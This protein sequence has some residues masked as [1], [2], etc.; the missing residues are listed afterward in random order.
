[1]HH[2]RLAVA[3]ACAN[4]SVRT[5]INHYGGRLTRVDSSVNLTEYGA[6]LIGGLHV[7]ACGLHFTEHEFG[8]GVAA[9]D[10]SGAIGDNQNGALISRD[11]G[12][13]I[14]ASFAMR[15]RQLR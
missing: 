10:A 15:H 2:P 11:D 13:A 1:V 5:H 8:G 12:Y 3:Y 9:S 7:R 4:E 14:L 6:P